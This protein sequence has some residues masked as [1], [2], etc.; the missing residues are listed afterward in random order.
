MVDLGFKITGGPI[1][2]LVWANGASTQASRE[3]VAMWDR[4][5]QQADEIDCLTRELADLKARRVGNL[6]AAGTLHDELMAVQRELA[7]ARA[8]R[9]LQATIAANEEARAREAEKKFETADKLRVFWNDK[10]TALAEMS[11]DKARAW[12]ALN[13]TFER[14][15]RKAFE[16]AAEIAENAKI[17]GKP[18]LYREGIAALLRKALETGGREG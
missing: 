7:E 14:G 11:V 18:I 12:D 16:E 6:E 10:A 2:M 17:N 8:S 13:A 15:R 5:S 9:D 3:E 1:K 4:V